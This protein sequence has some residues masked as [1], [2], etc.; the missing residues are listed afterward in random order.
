LEN[1]LKYID[2]LKTLKLVEIYWR[3]NLKYKDKYNWLCY[4]FIIREASISISA[5]NLRHGDNLIFWIQV[6]FLMRW[7]W[8]CFHVEHNFK[9][10]FR[11]KIIVTLKLQLW[12]D[13][14]LKKY[15]INQQFSYFPLFLRNHHLLQLYF[16]TFFLP[17][18]CP[19]IFAANV[20]NKSKF[21]HHKK[22]S[23]LKCH[24]QTTTI[25]IF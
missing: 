7:R 1:Y 4:I 18:L 25:N 9:I 19:C 5:K 16:F 24:P 10:R 14:L 17:S 22:Y 12:S 2:I 23:S 11:S 6:L 8:S 3:L 13:S 15:S 20:T 21:N